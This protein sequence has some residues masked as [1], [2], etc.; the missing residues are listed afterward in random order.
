ME[1]ASG[2]PWNAGKWSGTEQRCPQEYRGA[3]LDPDLLPPLLR[4]MHALP[5]RIALVLQLCDLPRVSL[6]VPTA[7]R[8]ELHLPRVGQG[9]LLHT[10]VRM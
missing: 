2:R 4:V 10:F 7:R 5:E 3:G 1:A 6:F 8:R 9:A